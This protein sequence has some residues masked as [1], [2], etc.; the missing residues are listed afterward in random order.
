VLV[1]AMC[2]PIH[3]RLRQ[4][5]AEAHRFAWPRIALEERRQCGMTPG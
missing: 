3:L 1:S 2:T 5:L 4:Y